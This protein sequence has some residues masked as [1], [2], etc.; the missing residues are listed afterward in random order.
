MSFTSEYA[1]GIMAAQRQKELQ[2]EAAQER[3][4]R[5]ARGDEASFW[6]RLFVSTSRRLSAGKRRPV[7]VI[8][9]RSAH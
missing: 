6:Q 1:I 9:H 2:A 4:A 7:A 3:L 5:I 8:R